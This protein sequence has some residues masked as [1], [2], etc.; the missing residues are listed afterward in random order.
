MLTLMKR[1]LLLAA[2]PLTILL[3]ACTPR[4]GLPSAS[5]PAPEAVWRSGWS[6][7]PLPAGN[8]VSYDNQTV[9]QSLW[10]AADGPQIRLRLSNELGTVPVRVGTVRVGRAGPDGALLSGSDQP[11]LFGGGAAAALPPGAPLL[12]DP[13]AFPVAKGERLVVSIHYP[14]P[15]IVAGH[16]PQVEISPPGDF[17]QA[18]RLPN[19]EVKRAPSLIGAVEVLTTPV[20]VLVAIG[21]SI[22]EGDVSHQKPA[23]TYPRQLAALLAQR[24]DL[25]VP[26]II[27]NEG[28]SGNRLLTDGAGANLL[29][30]F[31][32]D[33]LAKPGVT[34]IVVLI[35]INDIG[36]GFRRP[37]EAVSA[38]ALIQGL[39]QLRERAHAKGV[40]IHLGTIMPYE[41][42]GYFSPEGEV[43]RQQVNDWIRS[44]PG[45]DGIVDFDATLRDPAKPSQLLPAYD[46][47]DKLHPSEA[48]YGAMAAAAAKALFPKR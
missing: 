5:V 29:A 43:K 11:V 12:S 36:S 3:S 19:P 34:D 24:G 39:A 42:A 48:G 37:P 15:T 45:I 33:A 27:L 44:K 1:R 10:V 41:G 35:G 9:R 47:G 25:A 7:S 2:L 20:P 18:P 13:L 17:T 28:I 4:D 26:P 21:D 16:R 23:G 22:T 40:R 6:L 32:R 31:D 30:R 38:Q 14:Q 46:I 8:E